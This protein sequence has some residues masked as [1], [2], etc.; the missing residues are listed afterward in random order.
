M[1]VQVGVLAI[2]HWT[3]MFLSRMIRLHFAWSLRTRAASVSGGPPTT[4]QPW[5]S[6]LLL[7]EESAS[8]AVSEA[9]NCSTTERGV[10]AG[11]NRPTHDSDSKP[12]KVSAMVG[13]S[14]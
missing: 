3:V 12:G 6:N 11:A 1:L 7:T 4:S 8:M 9:C 13:S 10:A 2:G 5:L 14:A